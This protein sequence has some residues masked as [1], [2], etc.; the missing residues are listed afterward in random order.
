M[1]SENIEPVEYDNAVDD[2]MVNRFKSFLASQKPPDKPQPAKRTPK[3]VP[4]T[5]EPPP[6][7]L[8][9]TDSDIQQKPKT[10][11]PLTD[12]QRETLIKGRERRDAIRKERM[13]EKA[14]QDAEYQ[15]QLEEKIIKK[16]IQL[17][18]KQIKQQ[19]VIEPDSESEEMPPPPTLRRRPTIRA[20]VPTYHEPPPPPQKHIIFF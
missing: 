16:A 14:R 20:K 10:K 15:K 17:K 18:K 9:D 8:S 13:E 11:R 7:M 5:V 12:K 4:T 1:E 6:L 2:D 19:K 3:V